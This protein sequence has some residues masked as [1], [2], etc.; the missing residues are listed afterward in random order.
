[1]SDAKRVRRKRKGAYH[2]GDLHDAI[3]GAATAEVTRA[4]PHALT[5]RSVAERVG[6]TH[7]AVYHHFADRTAMITAVARQAFLELGAEMDHAAEGAK[8]PLE[9]Y[10]RLGLAYTRYAL[11]HPALYAVMFGPEAIATEPDLARAADAVFVRIRDAIVE[12]QRSGAI[13]AG[14]PEQ[15]TVFC[16]S[17]VHGFASLAIDR[18]LGRVASSLPA[19]DELA[20]MIVARVLTGLRK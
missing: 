16:W 12:C 9:R 17:V 20:E 4:G 6:V 15:H 11:R 3:V 7:A 5:I 8:A 10:G 13:A 19:I 2:H 1:M 18:Q 14:S